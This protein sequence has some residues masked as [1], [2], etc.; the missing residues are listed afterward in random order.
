[1]DKKDMKIQALLER[2]STD[3]AKYE[4]EIANLRVEYTAL[5]QE[6]QALDARLEDMDPPNVTDPVNGEDPYV[7]VEED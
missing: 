6:K 4:E 3:K 2:M 1:M 7:P 5:S